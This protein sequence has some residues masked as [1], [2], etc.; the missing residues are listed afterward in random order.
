M[1]GTGST[2]IMCMLALCLSTPSMAQD[3]V[4]GVYGN[5]S[6]LLKKG[7]SFKALGINA[8]FIHKASLTPELMSKAKKEGVKVYAEFPLLNGK[9]Y[10]AADKSAWPID[11]NGDPSPQ[12]DWFMG[13]CPSNPAF[14]KFRED[15][16]A[17]LLNTYAVDGVWLDYVHW[18]AQFESPE[19]ILPETCFCTHCLGDF[20]KATG[21]IVPVGDT[22]QKAA[23]ILREKEKEWRTWR[24]DIIIDW[25]SDFCEVVHRH[26]PRAKLG[27]YYCP[28]FPEDFDGALYRILGLDV[29][30]LYR[31]ADVLSPMIYHARMGRDPK[32][33]TAYLEWMQTEIISK[34]PGKAA[35]WP[36]VQASNEGRTVKPKEF[37]DVMTRGMA[38]PSTGIMMFSTS[39]FSDDTVKIDVM[40]EIY[41]SG[42][43]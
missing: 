13:I 35:I 4:K 36:I 32:W 39:A 43:R 17:K 9:D 41:R 23:W 15:E 22:N 18:H 16:L 11:A 2:L 31:A 6:V 29:K 33:V 3:L 24:S 40:K 42:K 30:A 1:K 14:R 27:V 25:V 8:V 38:R 37:R 19:P 12:A 26:N 28:W 34:E 5:P 10:L 21:I 20:S 7:Y